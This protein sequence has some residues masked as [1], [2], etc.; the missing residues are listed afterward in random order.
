MSLIYHCGPCTHSLLIN[1]QIFN[2]F[3]QLFWC[4]LGLGSGCNSRKSKSWWRWRWSPSWTN[5]F[6][7]CTAKRGK[8]FTFTVHFPWA[9]TSLVICVSITT[10][11]HNYAWGSYHKFILIKKLILHMAIILQGRSLQNGMLRRLLL[12]RVFPKMWH[13]Y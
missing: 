13:R 3:N 5:Y 12:S 10:I 7:K 1:S 9:D 2:P 6:S 11:K 8:C 4:F